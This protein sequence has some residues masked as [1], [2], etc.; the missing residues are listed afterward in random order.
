[1]EKLV[2]FSAIQELKES[3]ALKK[4]KIKQITKFKHVYYIEMYNK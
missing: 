3:K 2:L 4:I 1:M